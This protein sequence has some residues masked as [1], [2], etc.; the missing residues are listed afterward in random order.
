MAVI[1]VFDIVMEWNDIGELKDFL[2]CN[3]I[4]YEDVEI[5]SYSE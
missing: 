1:K 3:N 2:I 5:I 4:K